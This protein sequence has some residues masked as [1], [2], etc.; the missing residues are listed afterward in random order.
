M[1]GHIEHCNV[2]LQNLQCLGLALS[3]PI[4]EYNLYHILHIRG[5]FRYPSNTFHL[6]PYRQQNGQDG[7]FSIYSKLITLFMQNVEQKYQLTQFHHLNNI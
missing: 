7:L 5:A 3:S 2:K 6:P 4:N 1:P